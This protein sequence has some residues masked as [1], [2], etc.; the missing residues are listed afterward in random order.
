MRLGAVARI[1]FT[2][3]LAMLALPA[4]A[5]VDDILEA[6]RQSEF[7]FARS[8][9]NVP[10]IPVGW[11]QYHNYP[12]TEFRDD[13]SLLAPAEAVEHAV[14]LGAIAPVYVD[15][16]DMLLLG[17]DF[18]WDSISV[19]S[20]PYRD[21]RIARITPVAAWLHQFGTRH[22]VGA[23][24]APILSKEFEQDRPWSTNGFTGLIGM[25]WYSDT[26]QWVYGG[27]Y[28]TYFGTGYFYPYLGLQWNPTPQWSVALLFPW[29]T[30][31]YSPAKSWLL[32]VGIAPGGSSWAANDNGYESTQAFGS[33]NTT[34]GIGYQ[35]QG[36]W[37]LF[38]GA[39]IAGFRGVSQRTSGNE[40]R[41]D[42]E[43][44]PVYTLA[45]QFRP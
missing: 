3:L 44:S 31:T 42:A 12:S 28:E 36:G 13:R 2:T 21:Q 8:G 35:L 10:F 5:A 6:I 18:A 25:Y 9:S 34:L 24:V 26:Y 30:V 38:A 16:R 20:G 4:P 15:R 40:V 32:Q 45:I 7:R 33:W 19:T 27:V 17:S 39:G 41:L 14:S 43:P 23:F 37:W 22:T 1:C 11:L 29:P